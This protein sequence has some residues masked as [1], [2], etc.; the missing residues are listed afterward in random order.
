MNTKEK[1]K[2]LLTEYIITND[3]VDGFADDFLLYFIVEDD[4]DIGDIIDDWYNDI[5]S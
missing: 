2:Y 1:L 5:H 3:D 4:P